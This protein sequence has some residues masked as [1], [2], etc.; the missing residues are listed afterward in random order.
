L[1]I[2]TDVK[3]VFETT[4]TLFFVSKRRKKRQSLRMEEVEK[5]VEVGGKNGIAG[6][7]SIC[8][9]VLMTS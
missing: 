8:S 1:V 3:R 9:E 6:R 2:K 4:F 5:N 7:E